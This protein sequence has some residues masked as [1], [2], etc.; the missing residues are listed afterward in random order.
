M[1]KLKYLLERLP[2]WTLTLVC[3]MAILWLTLASKPLGDN[4]IEL[5]PNADKVAHAIMFGG[6]TFCILLDYIRRR[7]WKK[8]TL[9]IEVISIIASISLGAITEI[10]QQSM[11][12]GRSGDALDLLAD[13]VG[14]I[15]TASAFHIYNFICLRNKNK[16]VE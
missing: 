9:K 1:K 8:P 7:E 5:F 15:I 10:L 6:F 3:L 13:S 16:F 4:E 2:S 14:A 11:H 12:A